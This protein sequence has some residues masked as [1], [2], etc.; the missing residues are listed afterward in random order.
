MP[1]LKT[2]PDS[3]SCGVLR[4]LADLEDDPLVMVV[5]APHAAL[6]LETGSD[7]L[8]RGVDLPFVEGGELLDGS[9]VDE[10]GDR[11]FEHGSYGGRPY[12]GSLS[13]ERYRCDGIYGRFA[14][15]E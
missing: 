3:C 1:T 2:N 6:V 13:L 7:C 11:L 4:V 15:S 14:G 5:G 12:R 10:G 8:S 9:P